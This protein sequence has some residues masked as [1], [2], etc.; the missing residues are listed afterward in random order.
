[1]LY[2]SFSI[3]LEKGNEVTR[4]EDRKFLPKKNDYKLNQTIGGKFDFYYVNY[5][6]LCGSCRNMAKF[7]QL[8]K[9]L[10]TI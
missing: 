3:R 9:K 6:L 5:F 10:Q 4:K 2:C 8:L 7:C 1:M